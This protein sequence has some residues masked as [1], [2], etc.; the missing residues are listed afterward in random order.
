MDFDL[1]RVMFIC[2]ANVLDTIPGPL[3]DRMEIIQLPGYTEEEKIQIARRYLV[4][5]QLDA[6]GLKAD[7]AS[8]TDAALSA[9][10]R[11]Y[12]REAGV[13]N[14]EREIGAVLRHAAMGIAEGQAQQ[15]AADA[16]DLPAILGARRFENE[17][18]LRTSLP[19]VATGLAWTPVGGDILFIEA[20]KVPGSGR[21]ILTGQLGDVMKESA[22]A[23]LTLAKTFTGD[24][25]EKL[26]IH[27]HVPACATPKDGPSAGVAMFLALVSL[28]TGK[29]VRSDVAMT[30][31]V[32]LQGLVL[33]I[34]GVKEKTLAALRAG[35]HTVM[36]PRRNQKDLEDV[37]A[38]AREKLR[39][40]WLDRVEDAVRCAIDRGQKTDEGHS[41]EDRRQG[42]E[43]R[44]LAT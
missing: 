10:V 42:T 39:F 12:T 5:R 23:A 15:V 17:A 35:V 28:L 36:L 3:R 43:D 16:A 9:I 6:N 8:L 7:Q 21:L 11:D 44:A 41:A 31:E 19:G 32:S 25:L 40:V 34:G 37:P 26:D 18:A 13:R 33:P 30:G 20:A 24:S 38:E 4:K 22:R 29:P 1:S 2:T 14:L 27:V